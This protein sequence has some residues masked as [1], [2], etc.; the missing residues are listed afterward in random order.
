MGGK[1]VG[2]LFSIFTSRRTRDIQKDPKIRRKAQTMSAKELIDEHLSEIRRS[3]PEL[4]GCYK[5]RDS[6]G[7]IIYIGK[8]KNL[9]KR[10]NSYFNRGDSLDFKTRL[11]VRKIAHIEFVITNSEMDALLLE[12]NLIK[13]HQP[14]YNI[15][16]RDGK[17]YPYI[18]V[19]DENFPRV[20]M[21]RNRVKDGSAYYGPYPQGG[22]MRSLLDFIR[23]N[24]KLRTCTYHLSDANIEAGKFR[25]CLEFQIGKCKAPCVG[26]QARAEYDA[27]VA[28]IHQILRGN[29]KGVIA[30]LEERMKA[31]ALALRFEEA[32]DMKMRTEALRK[33]RRKNIIIS[34]EITD[35][36]VLTVLSRENLTVVNYFKILN[37]T[38][39]RTQAFDVWRKNGETEVEVFEAVLSKLLCDDPDF[40]K[41]IIVNF[42]VPELQVTDALK[43]IIPKRGDLLKV[44]Q[45]SEKNCEA[46]L[47]EKLNVSRIRRHE[48]QQDTMLKQAKEDLRLVELPRHIECFD[49]SNL[50]GDAA[51]SSVVVFKDGKPARRE[52]RVFNVQTVVGPDDY[53][54]M[55]EAV[56][57]RYEGLLR[58][59]QELPNLVVIDGGKGQLSF[60][61]RALTDLGI[62]KRVALISIAKRLEE[63]YY[64]NDPDPLYIDKR[65]PTLKLI[66]RLRN[67]AHDTAIKF[68]RRKR[69][70]QSL[71]T[72]LTNIKGVGQATAKKLLAELRSVKKVQEADLETLE[73]LLGPTK[74][75]VV[76]GHFRSAN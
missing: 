58:D 15:A 2:I 14:P 43:F 71:Q 1:Q 64:P 31:A 74:A 42:E 61:L 34:D 39:M 65:S 44:M 18:V 73:K 70:R 27:D 13:E 30:E 29:F 76:Y 16:L 50:Q 22:A 24:Y 21:T 17:T 25:S 46:V 51:V 49:N 10:V 67:E 62:E 7:K 57:R 68:H 11:L 54:T 33:F 4:P 72:E 53:A 38:I 48:T 55:Y 63:I 47:E 59:G 8:A 23:S 28:E 66:Q 75:K 26:K 20:F 37:G 6:T 35:V 19:K 69:S 12:N 9:R 32:H 56:H 41:R 36:E 5:Y 40:A 60:A 45:L 3:L 52:Y